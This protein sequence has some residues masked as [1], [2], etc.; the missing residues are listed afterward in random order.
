MVITLHIEKLQPGLY[1]TSALC[2]EVLVTQHA[3]YGFLEDA[4]REEAQAIPDGFAWFA[5][6]RYGGASSGTIPL[7]D[8]PARAADVAAHL[9]GLVAQTHAIAQSAAVVQP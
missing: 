4:I 6:V 1:R 8:L 7:K 2:G 9:V 5:E 3:T